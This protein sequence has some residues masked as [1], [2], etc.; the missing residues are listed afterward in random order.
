M[1]PYGLLNTG[2]KIS[3]FILERSKIPFKYE[4]LS[5]VLSLSYPL[6]R[7]IQDDSFK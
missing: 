3:S 5:I 6:S 1:V 2:H 4:S 7:L